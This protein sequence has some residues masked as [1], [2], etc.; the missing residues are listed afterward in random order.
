EALHQRYDTPLSRT[1]LADIYV[2]TGQ[3]APAVLLLRQSAAASETDEDNY[4]A[5]LAALSAQDRAYREEFGKYVAGRLAADIPEKRKLVLAYALINAHAVQ[6]AMPYIRRLAEKEGGQWAM[7]YADTLDKEGRHD[8]ARPFWVKVARQAATDA[9]EKRSIAYTLL[10]YGYK[11]DAEDIFFRLA[12]HAPADS[13][14]VKSLV[15]VWGP[16][17]DARQLAWIEN[18]FA[19]AEDADREDWAKLL[20]N[21]ADDDAIIDFAR[22]QPDGLDND[23]LAARYFGALG[24]RGELAAQTGGIIAAAQST[25][26]TDR[27][28]QFAIAAQENG[29]SAEARRAWETALALHPDD[30]EAM[31]QIGTIALG[32]GDAAAAKRYLNAY[33]QGGSWQHAPPKD[34]YHLFFDYAEFLRGRHHAGEAKSYYHFTIEL[35]DNNKLKD[36]GAQSVKAQS[37]V[38]L[39]DVAGG[40]NTFEDA[41]TAEPGNAMLRADWIGVL[42]NLGRYD[43]ARILLAIPPDA[44]FNRNLP[45]VMLPPGAIAARTL[46]NGNHELWL[47]MSQPVKG[48][49]SLSPPWKDVPWI[50]Y[51]GQGY[52]TLLVVPKP[53]YTIAIDARM[54]TITATPDAAAPALKERQQTLLRFAELTTIADLDTGHVYTAVKRVERLIPG[55]ADDPSFLSFAASVENAGGNWPRAEQLVATACALSPQNEGL[56][57]FDRD[58]HRSYAQNVTINSDWMN[59][60]SD[61]EFVSGV[62]GYVDVNDHMQLGMATQENQLQIHDGRRPDG[63][64]GHFAGSRQ[65]GEIY[66]QS[67]ASGGEMFK[68]SLFGNNRTVGVGGY[69]H[70]LN[71]LGETLISAEWNKPYWDI[72]EA[73]FDDA[74]RDRLSLVQTV[75]PTP[76]LAISGGPAINRYNSEGKN[77]LATSVSGTLSASYLL[78]DGPPSLALVYGF[79]AEYVQRSKY[80]PDATGAMTRLFPLSSREV[81]SLSFGSGY[82]FND[83]LSGAM[84]AG[85]AYDQL[86]GHGAL[87]STS[88]TWE[89]SDAIEMQFRASSGLESTSTANAATDV[90]GYVR[91]RF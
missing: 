58:L 83:A 17:P 18:R 11:A 52:D 24:A 87:L 9:K 8:E 27:L 20:A 51:I 49:V 36:S 46:H 69:D 40:M 38:Q 4:I 75:K 48:N 12:A 68:F 82:T 90:G 28:R 15:Y 34:I 91:W 62:S 45:P 70:F 43:E 67:Y 73:A 6:Y 74:T 54:E 25:H 72:L 71:P 57:R 55:H 63:S 61:S 88:L 26:Q 31:R 33:I 42:L 81:H 66:L 5:A 19:Y 65:R 10:S 80:G 30:S 37:Q 13:D 85:Y 64:V 78:I 53:G 86:G 84:S 23:A 50:S 7:F 32:Q 79:D 22:R 76:R 21:V 56:A 77:D 1:L 16:R 3:F 2:R 14:A 60:G 39:G 44:S 35:I 41:V 47:R 89:I 59:F 29:L